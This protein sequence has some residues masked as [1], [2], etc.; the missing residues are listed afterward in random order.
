MKAITKAAAFLDRDGV[1]NYDLGYVGEISRFQFIPKAA[2]ACHAL[3][4]MGYQLIV[5]TNQGGIALGRYSEEDY[6]TITDH[7]TASLRAQGAHLTAV[8]HSPYHPRGDDQYIAWRDW[9]KPQPGMLLAAAKEHHLDLRRSL[10]VGDKITDMQAAEAA[11]VP[12]RY[13]IGAHKDAPAGTV[14][15]S[16]LAAVVALLQ[17]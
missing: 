7:M 2:A 17:K 13:F 6:H 11:G 3:S 4:Q 15:C 16:S 9:R 14:A 10:M 5:V 12:Q 8:Y 1:I